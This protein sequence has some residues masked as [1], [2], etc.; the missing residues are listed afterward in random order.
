M[1][2]GDVAVELVLN[3]IDQCNA[4][5]DLLMLQVEN[6]PDGENPTFLNEFYADLCSVWFYL[7]KVVLVV[8]FRLM[9]AF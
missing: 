1:T 9:C 4:A 7:P 5:F 6:W 8:S 3:W 2:S